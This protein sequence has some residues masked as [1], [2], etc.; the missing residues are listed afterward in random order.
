MLLKAPEINNL[1]ICLI[2]NLS[3]TEWKEFK[4]YYIKQELMFAT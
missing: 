2:K 4:V 3:D 1:L